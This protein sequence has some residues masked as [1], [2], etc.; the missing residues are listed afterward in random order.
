MTDS[1]SLGNVSSTNGTFR[2]SGTAS[3]LD[4]ESIVEAAYEAKRFA[5]V[6]LERKIEVN[7]AK[8]A[9][10]N[11]LSSILGDIQTAVDGLRNP[12]GFFG[13]DTNVFEN[14][15]VF[16]TS[17]SATVAE[18]I[19]GIAVENSAD[20]GSFELE[21]ETLA[22]AHKLSAGSASSQDQT[23]ADALNGGAAFSGT[24]DISVDGGDVAT[25]AID[26]T[27]KIADLKTA[28]EA[29]SGT[30]GVTASVLQVS[31]SDFRLVLSAQDTNKT[32]TIADNSG[33]AGGF[34]SSDI[35]TPN[36]ATFYVDGV[37]MTRD[38]NEI[39]DVIEGVT[40]SLF[41]E[42]PGTKI[43]VEVE[44]SL[45][46]AKEKIVD[47]VNAYNAF[48]DFVDEQ[49]VVS[50]DGDLA[51][52]SVLFG[53]QTLRR[54]TSDLTSLLG[55]S[56]DGLDA[57]SIS[58]LRDIGIT[59]NGANRLAVD[60]SKMDSTLI[61]KLDEL[62]SIFEFSAVSVP[63]TLTVTG[64][65]N[66]FANT[67]FNVQIVDADNDGVPESATIDGIAADVSNRAIT[68]PEGSAYEGL[69]FF[70]SG[71]GSE[72]VAVSTSQ[73]IADRLYNRIEQVIDPLGGELET[74]IDAIEGITEDYNDDILRINE[75]A[76]SA[77]DL[78]IEKFTAMEAALSLAN[79]MLEQVKAQS[80]AWSGGG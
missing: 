55:A 34:Q 22:T 41:K 9:A 72:T 57:D 52:G 17:N 8:I 2:L 7:D 26:G 27:M 78:L 19:A 61:G 58:T 51:E 46:D 59:I 47:F 66:S 68:A 43:T 53:D 36:P 69:S 75:R 16:L 1:I 64:R 23:L 39:D 38:G 4:T 30:S 67:D 21:V 45:Q 18:S 70:W 73:G 33:I 48:R 44:P 71:T 80:R 76:E 3:D 77:R 11:D 50:E 28:I 24:L 12:P 29:A 32:I 54:L 60:D 31:D 37:Q 13:T 25:V 42:E 74:A 56:V 35:Q 5:A 63:A 65:S 20:T 79:S 62:R 14:K 40:F 10:Y 49:S 6:R 15:Q